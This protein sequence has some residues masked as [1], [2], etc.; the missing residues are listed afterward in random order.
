MFKIPRHPVEYLQNIARHFT[1]YLKHD[2]IEFIYLSNEIPI[3]HLFHF[4][5]LLT[6]KLYMWDLT[7]WKSAFLTHN[8][9]FDMYSGRLKEAEEA[10]T[11]I[12]NCYLKLSGTEIWNERFLDSLVA[13]II[14][15][16]ESLI[17]KDAST[18][19]K[20][21]ESLKK[22]Y[23]YLLKCTEGGIKFSVT[24]TPEKATEIHVYN[25]QLIDSSY[26]IYGRSK[27]F[28]AVYTMMDSPNYMDSFEPQVAEL[29][30][31][32]LDN[33]I[34][35]SKKISKEGVKDRKQ[36]FSKLEHN[37]DF[38]I[39]KIRKVAALHL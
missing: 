3:F 5:E 9:T 38:N 19:D 15:L 24:G 8:F 2:D 11:S 17:I 23:E 20:L 37:L 14:F 6:L 27:G 7:N 35:H 13:Q 36:F 39:E 21:I 29:T 4:P 30:K 12:I 1:G 32:W 25:N 10:R 33:V 16:I 34:I 22:L 28:C 26:I 18:V 31:K